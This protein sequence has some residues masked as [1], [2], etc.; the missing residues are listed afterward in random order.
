M[1]HQHK[2][3]E[4]SFRALYIGLGFASA[5]LLGATSKD[6]IPIMTAPTAK[7]CPD[8]QGQLN[9]LL[10]R[11][12]RPGGTIKYDKNGNVTAVRCAE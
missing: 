10:D 4:V 1:K 12:G 11:C 5:L 7:P 8:S 9:A 2:I 3:K 6:T